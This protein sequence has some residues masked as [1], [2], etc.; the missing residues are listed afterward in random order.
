MSP[1]LSV[2]MATE[3]IWSVR[4]ATFNLSLG[5]GWLVFALMTLMWSG[6]G[7]WAEVIDGRSKQKTNMAM[8]VGAFEAVGMSDRCCSWGRVCG[9]IHPP[10]FRVAGLLLGGG[11]SRGG[12]RRG[13]SWGRR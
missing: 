9:I 5:I 3:P 13:R 4:R 2:A 6:C 8:A 7:D 12:R 10:R 1:F 11:P